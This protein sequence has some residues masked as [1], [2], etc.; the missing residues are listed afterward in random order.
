MVGEGARACARQTASIRAISGKANGLT[1]VVV[2]AGGEAGDA[3]FDGAEGG[4]QDDGVWMPSA[5]SSRSTRD[6]GLPGA[7]G[8]E[9]M[10]WY[11]C[12]RASL[13]PFFAILGPDA[14]VARFEKALAAALCR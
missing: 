11:C 3:L 8:R 5:R 14:L 2:G 9:M 4:Q 7:S 13:Q 1:S 10:A 12:V 6:P